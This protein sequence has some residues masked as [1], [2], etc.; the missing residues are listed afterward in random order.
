MFE[1]TLQQFLCTGYSILGND[2]KFCN[3]DKNTKFNRRKITHC[4]TL[5]HVSIQ[6]LPKELLA[7]E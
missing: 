1:H 6:R 3:F 5:W 4:T 2:Y 7:G